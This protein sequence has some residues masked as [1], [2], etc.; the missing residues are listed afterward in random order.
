MSSNITISGIN[1]N[2]PIGGLNNSSQGFR[3]NFAAIAAALST[4]K[5][6]ITLLQGIAASGITGPY[7]PTG[8]SN[9]P[10]GYTGPTGQVGSTGLQ[11]PTGYLGP[12]G[13]TGPTG[14]IGIGYTG[15]AST[16]TG[17]TGYH[18]PTGYTGPASTITGPT[19]ATGAASTV[20]G[21]TGYHGPT[22]AQGPTGRGLQGIQGVQGARG[23]TG[24]TGVLGRQ[25]VT[26]PRGIQGPTGRA[27]IG[28]TGPQGPQGIAGPTG[29]KGDVGMTGPSATL[30]SSYDS[31]QSGNIILSRSVGPITI[32]DGI[33]S[34]GKLFVVSDRFDTTEYFSV[35][36]DYTSLSGNVHAQSS[37]EWLVPG[38]N[39]NRI[40]S[41]LTDITAFTNTLYLQSAGNYDNGGRIVFGTGIPDVSGR[42]AET[43]RIDQNGNFGIGTPSP[44]YRLDIY[45]TT[46]SVS[47]RISAGNSSGLLTINS[48]EF[49]IN[50]TPQSNIRIGQGNASV[51]INTA[52]GNVG[53][54]T[55]T[56]TT[57]F[58]INKSV[59]ADIGPVLSLKNA[60]GL[61]GDAA[62]I[63]FDVGGLLPNATIDVITDVASDT[64]LVIKTRQHEILKEA[65]VINAPTSNVGIGT[66]V[67]PFKLTVEGDIGVS[68]GI[69]FP[70]GTLLTSG[71]TNKLID[72]AST[73]TLNSTSVDFATLYSNGPSLF[74]QNITG[75]S[76]FGLNYNQV[77]MHASDYID[78]SAGSKLWQFL[79]DGGFK[80]PDGTIQR[81]A[82]NQGGP[83]TDY[84]QNSGFFLQLN[85]DGSI[86]FPEVNSSSQTVKG[87][88]TTIAGNPYPAIAPYSG[89]DTFAIYTA[90]TTSVVGVSMIIK[91]QSI[92]GEDNVTEICQVSAVKSPDGTGGAFA[93][94]YGQITSQPTIPFTKFDADVDND[95]YLNI[96]AD[97]SQHGTWRN[98]TYSVTEFNTTL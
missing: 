29:A 13:N 59:H 56:P 62:Q 25:G 48:T 43:A 24:P 50:T 91:C 6:E 83:G 96:S 95:G 26:G 35:T 33:S 60:N 87:T 75:S 58:Q 71:T 8:P 4:A 82:W 78:V 11:G 94:V 92:E 38:Y 63:R 74:I 15:A 5:S 53:I 32:K 41:N 84:L 40:F 89:N 3:D 22:G 17:P 39:S 70:N 30:Q 1:V 76:I 52:T 31:S 46:P 66:T 44:T 7:G 69:S 23:P 88:T 72:A 2:F 77:E 65:V 51:L 73:L 55:S 61:L 19:G 45:G 21:P 14:P 49:K 28:Y 54:G 42:R 10:T 9:G 79:S 68:G 12:R 20:T 47:T 64:R 85:Q 34:L 80:F 36:T 37:T 16:V 93:T 86:S 27:G 97:S 90:S 98:I 67:T 57:Q 81:S 18:G